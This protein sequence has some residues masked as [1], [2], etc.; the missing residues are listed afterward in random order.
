MANLGLYWTRYRMFE[1]K[2]G[3]VESDDLLIDIRQWNYLL[4]KSPPV[5]ALV[6]YA[7]LLFST[8]FYQFWTCQKQMV[9][10][11]R[12]KLP[13]LLVLITYETTRTRTTL[14]FTRA[15]RALHSSQT[16][17]LFFNNTAAVTM[18]YWLIFICLSSLLWLMILI[19]GPWSM[20]VWLI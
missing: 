13:P 15:M 8:L 10:R 1:I 7:S 16:F 19:F 9:L 17:E 20:Y 12:K 11:A 6:N 18:L 2:N 5:F 4:G 14:L 3:I